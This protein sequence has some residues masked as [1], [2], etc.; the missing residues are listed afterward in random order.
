MAHE[1]KVLRRI[2]EQ[3]QRSWFKQP[4]GT[5]KGKCLG[6]MGTGSIGQEIAGTA[7]RFGMQVTG[8]SRSG[9]KA[10]N[11][12]EVFPV[13]GLHEFLAG[14]DHL[15]ATLPHTEDTDNLLDSNALAN[16]PAHAYFVNVGRS[17][18]V[19]DNN[20]HSFAKCSAGTNSCFPIL[21]SGRSIECSDKGDCYY[22]L[23][24]RISPG[25]TVSS[26]LPISI[27]F[28]NR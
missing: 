18:V 10:P 8:L 27:G 26:D 4:S 21:I 28:L 7:K 25:N 6:I 23:P 9:M 24:V 12:D 13:S 22:W 16:L 20:L 11:F 14:I 17:N 15:V 19:D 3:R 2:E 1:L 5:L